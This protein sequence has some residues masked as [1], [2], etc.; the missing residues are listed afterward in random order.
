MSPFFSSARSSGKNKE[1]KTFFKSPTETV[2][3]V[4]IVTD[5]TQ[6]TG[7]E[8]LAEAENSLTAEEGKSVSGSSSGRSR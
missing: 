1:R 5:S 2:E 7:T 8:R 4:A 6:L 3:V